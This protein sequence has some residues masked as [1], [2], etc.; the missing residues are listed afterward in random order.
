M[1][2]TS[3]E[4]DWRQNYRKIFSVDRHSITDVFDEMKL[5][6]KPLTYTHQKGESISADAYHRFSGLLEIIGYPSLGRHEKWLT[7][8][9]KSTLTKSHNKRVL[10]CGAMSPISIAQALDMMNKAGYQG[11]ELT[12]VDI[13]NVP[14]KSAEGT[15]K[16]I[17]NRSNIKIDFKN[18]DIKDFTVKKHFGAVIAD[19][20]YNFINP[21]EWSQLTDHLAN[22]TD[23]EGSF[24][25][26]IALYREQFKIGKN[27][28]QI[29]KEMC[30]KNNG[31]MENLKPLK[32]YFYAN[33]TNLINDQVGIIT[34]G[35]KSV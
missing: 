8:N 33:F 7:N 2:N 16:T 29:L 5:A 27:A 23:W 28:R 20:I 15:L 32:R 1:I 14:Y 21:Y 9:L 35:K 6:L 19:Q 12:V 24:I 17:A 22:L 25:N 13:S 34:P 30:F 3:V 11:G 26:I 31:H 4:A 18:Q 10:L